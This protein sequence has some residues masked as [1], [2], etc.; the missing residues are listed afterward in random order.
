MATDGDAAAGAERGL[1]AANLAIAD[2]RAELHHLAAQ[3]VA[4]IDE[5]GRRLGEPLADAVDAAAAG[6]LDQI[7]VAIERQASVGRLHLGTEP[8][9]YAVATAD[10]PPCAELLPLCLARCC[11][12]RFALTSQDLDEGVIRWDHGTPYLIRHAGGRCVHHEPASGGCAEYAHRP[13]TCRSYDCRADPR[14]WIDYARRLPAPL[15]ALA[16]DPRP[17]EPRALIERVRARRRALA[18]EAHALREPAVPPDA[19]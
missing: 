7:E 17:I 13:A 9:K 15:E 18:T 12:L 14:V 3:V 10:G 16:V 4:L 5:V 19:E 6:V 2:V 8:D 1:R 11:R